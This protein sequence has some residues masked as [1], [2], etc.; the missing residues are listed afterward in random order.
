MS[1]GQGQAADRGP[2]PGQASPGAGHRGLTAGRQPSAEDV[3]GLAA[4]PLARLAERLRKPSTGSTTA[5]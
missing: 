5:G 3:L 1:A 2:A 4:E